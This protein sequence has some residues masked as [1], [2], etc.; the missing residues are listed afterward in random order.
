MG[1]AEGAV[2]W[3]ITGV[4]MKIWAAGACVATL[5]SMAALLAWVWPV[6]AA[7]WR[8]AGAVSRM[9]LVGLWLAGAGGLFFFPHDNSFTGLDDMAYRQ[10][11]HAFLDGRGFHDPDTVLAK[12]PARLKEDFLFYRGPWGR[13]TRDRLFQLSGWHSVGTKPFFMPVLSLAAAGLEPA[14][15]PE[16]FVPLVGV[17]GLALVLSS[18]FCAGGGWGLVAAGALVL[19]TAWPAW[20]LRGFYAEGAGA[21][22]VAGV[23]AAAA[24]RPLRGGGAARA[25]FALGLAVSYHPT[26]AVLSLPVALGLMLER[27]DGKSVAGLVAGG[28]AGVFPFWVLTR[29]VCQPYG[30]WT[31]G[32]V[33]R[34]LIFSGPEHRAIALTLVVLAVVSVA[35]LCAGFRP[36]VRAWVRQM[37]ERISPWGWLLIC[38]LPLILIA[39]LPGETGGQLREAAT[40]VWSGIRWPQGVLLLAA[41]GWVWTKQRPLR[42]RYWLVTVC[43]AAVFFLYIQGVETPV[44]LWSLRRFLPVSLVA[45][46][47]LASPLSAG[48]AETAARGR[49]IGGVALA[50]LAA[51]SGLWNVSHWPAATF[52]VNERGA[53][54][55]TQMISERIGPRR[56]VVF[57]YYPHSVPYA[58]DLKYKVLGVG[59]GS[60]GQWPEVARWLLGISRRKEVWVA[61]S[62]SPCTLEDGA[63]LEP[64]FAATGRFPVVKTKY[65]YPAERGER[66]VRNTFMRLVPLAKGTMA[67]QDKPMDGSPIGL[68]GP[69]GE[70]RRGATW[71]RQGS[72][73]IGPVPPQGGSV[74]FEAECEWTPPD[75]DWTQQILQVTTPWGG[76]PLRLEV[77]AGG[78]VVS[79]VLPRLEDDGELGQTG[80][81]S[82]SVERP[83]NPSKKGLRGYS[84]DLGVLIRRIIIRIEPT[85]PSVP[86]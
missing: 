80:V 23:M 69:W 86:N 67:H 1:I 85:R 78:H 33:L 31:R 62:W 76:E 65:F 26:L 79:G 50:L 54:E 57:D 32:A 81:Y 41:M 56:W 5:G 20:F 6:L 63:S 47:L 21:A 4:M 64:V 24:V 60:R 12:V 15:T 30:D 39:V 46:A 55:W 52:T 48:L 45:I 68:R 13:P 83:Y 29:W 59:E 28:L 22:L 37:D 7:K 11:S 10:L 44:G 27:R 25:G 51:I 35:A 38:A 73:I 74:V 77:Q 36:T 72:G 66:E 9:G 53:T 14:L 42:E 17:L 43:W 82:L 61:T 8:G 19:G 40:S 58:A 71:S 49:Q 2:R 18:A 16:R 75:P 84:P 3:Y 34:N 70:V